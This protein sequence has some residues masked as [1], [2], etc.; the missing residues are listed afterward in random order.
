[1]SQSGSESGI[2]DRGS[3]PDS[4]ARREE[5]SLVE[6]NKRIKILGEKI[7]KCLPITLDDAYCVIRKP[8][9]RV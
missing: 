8:F 5:D 4:T 9:R 2:I 7:D 1:M 6:I 3:I